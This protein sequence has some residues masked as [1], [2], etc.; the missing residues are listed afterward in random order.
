MPELMTVEELG[1]YL[2]FTKKT[3][4]KLLKQG[5]MPAIKIG[6]KWRFDKEA[7]DDWLHKSDE[8]A[9]ARI[10]VIDDDELIRSL[11]KEILEDQGHIVVTADTSAKGLSYVMQRDFDL[12]FLDLKMSGTDG[13]EILR[14]MKGVRR[15]LPVV[16]IT[17]YPDSD[18][19]D[20]AMKQGSLGIMLKP[21]DDSDVISAVNSFMHATQSTTRRK[22]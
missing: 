13:A 19:M 2:R 18:I 17:G 16:I 7:I 20:R 6:N 3:I 5:S 1:H 4:Y 9:R 22:Q 8:G 10:L 12:V 15:K 11:F 14:E 21:F